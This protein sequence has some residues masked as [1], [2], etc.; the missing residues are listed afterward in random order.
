MK[1]DR[2]N[3]ACHAYVDGLNLYYGSLVGTDL[4]WLD[5]V[6]LSTELAGEEPSKVRYFSAR[7]KSLPWNP[8]GHQR[9]DIYWQALRATGVG[10]VQGQFLVN[11]KWKRVAQPMVGFRTAPKRVQV[12]IPEEKG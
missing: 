2:S 8:H 5:L 7:V 4:K 3:G 10:I 9:Q 11:D 12:T 6:A 1:T